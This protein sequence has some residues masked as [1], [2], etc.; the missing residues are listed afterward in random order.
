[1]NNHKRLVCC[2]L[3]CGMVN[4]FSSDI[5]AKDN[6]QRNITNQQSHNDPTA[7]ILNDII[8]KI[9]TQKKE[10]DKQLKLLAKARTDQEKEKIQSKIDT[11]EQTIADQEDSFEMILTAGID[12]G[13]DETAAK[14]DFD[15]Q[16]DLIEIIQPFLRELHEL[17]ENKRKLDNLHFR[18][19]FYQQQIEKINEVLKHLSKINQENLQTEA[20]AE[21]ERINQKWQDQLDEGKHLFEVAQLQR[22]E[23]IQFKT[24]QERS[25]LNYLQEFSEGRGATLFLALTAFISVY[26]MMLLILKLFGLLLN[27]RDKKR[28]Y[29]QRLI[30]VLYYFLTVILAL[31]A[32]F[33]VL[34]ARDDAVMTGIMIVILIS[35]AWVLKNSIP[36]FFEELRL[37]LNTGSAREGECISYNGITMQIGSLHYYT[38]LTNPLLPGL[39]LRLTLSELA[40]YVSRP[41]SKDEPWFPCKVGDY[42]MLYG[43]IYGKVKNITLENIVLSLPD[44]TM[45]I[46]Y[47]IED[48]LYATPRNFSLGFVA[49]TTFGLDVKHLEMSTVEIPAIL[50]EGIHQ[51]ILKESFGVSLI[52]LSVHFAKADLSVLEYEIIANFDG[53]AANEFYSIIRA[54]QRYAVQICNEQQWISITE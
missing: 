11:L 42:V 1:M 9:S 22:D 5:Q 17:T 3:M 14:K 39:K 29:F 4:A 28:N 2:F 8:K 33:Y 12:L 52:D 45:P 31:T 25:F 20:L 54:L 27:G 50:T 36:A 40:K 32:F 21:F 43:D 23:M 6:T 19:N 7:T 16:Q 26:F 24:E 34:E 10:L 41:V 18:I 53:A 49:T 37:L 44:G 47:T 51:G 15:W 46:T 48:F 13:T 30:L 35:I 38:N